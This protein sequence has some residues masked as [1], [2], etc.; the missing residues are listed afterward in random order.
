MVADP[1]DL[2]A[3]RGQDAADAQRRMTVLDKYRKG[4][5]TPAD[6]TAAQSGAVSEVNKQ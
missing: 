3:P 6:T 5:S 4:E 2:V 1:R